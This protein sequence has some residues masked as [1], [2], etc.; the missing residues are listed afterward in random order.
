MNMLPKERLQIISE[1]VIE[2]NT[3]YVAELSKKL[4]VSEETIRRDLEKLEAQEVVIRSYGGAV[5]N[6]EKLINNK[7]LCSM[8]KT[9]IENEKYIA[10][11]AVDFIE[12]GSTI[13]ANYGSI[14]F[15]VLKYI[16]NRKGIT[17]VT[18]SIAVLQ[19][20]SQSSLNIISTGGNVNPESLSFEGSV[21]QDTIKKYNVD[22]ALIDCQGIDINK[23][24]LDSNEAEVEI[25]RTMI[26]QA[27]KVIV[28]AEQTKF[29]KTSLV[30]LFNYEDIDIII[31]DK[32]PREEWISLLHSHDIKSIY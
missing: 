19:E 22:I 21:T 13:V 9:N 24:I 2:E 16:K 7:P 6:P 25:K 30:K 23:G 11:K 3:V 17:V 15:E 4:N 29:D 14:T 28:L 20:L 8:R 18:N 31:T 26:K 5:L 1:M 10:R 32:E 27:N 12:E